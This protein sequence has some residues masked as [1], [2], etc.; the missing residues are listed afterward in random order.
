MNETF[1]LLAQH[2]V[3]PTV[4]IDDQRAA[5]PL[6]DALVEG[7]LPIVEV[8]LRTPDSLA[9]LERIIDRRDMIVGAGTVTTLAQFDAAWRL[10]ARFIVTPGLDE[11][12]LRHATRR[13]LLV[14][15]GAVTPTEIM[16]AQNLGVKMV[17]FFPSHVFGG[18]AAIEALAGPFSQMKF[19]P[20]GGIHLENLASYLQNPSV[21]ACG[22][23]WMAKREWVQQG[24]WEKIR[25][26]SIQTV[27]TVCTGI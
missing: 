19:L 7:G 13:D 15:P 25:Q 8:M 21:F 24:E 5:K 12:I 27:K 9:A 23:S 14:I 1:D 22:G 26:A 16:Q 20:T 18:M 4:V 17:K 6:S 11:N 10:G 2:R 3:I